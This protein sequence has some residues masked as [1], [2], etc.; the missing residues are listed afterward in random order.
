LTDNEHKSNGARCTLLTS[1]PPI[2][3]RPFHGRDFG[4]A[5]QIA[6]IN[7]WKAA[8][9]YVASLNRPHE[10]EAFRSFDKMIDLIELQGGNERPLISDFIAAAVKCGSKVVGIINA[11]CLLVPQIDFAKRLSQCLDGIALAERV[12][13]SGSTLRPVG[14]TCYGFDAMFFTIDALTSIKIG[15][16]HHA[17][18]IW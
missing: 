16:R 8:G 9:F 18:V 17:F 13:L 4:T 14:G 5:W 12:N 1:V 15:K 3:K 6:C 2:L 11:D 10:I 7:S